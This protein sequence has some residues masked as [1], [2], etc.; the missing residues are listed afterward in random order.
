MTIPFT[1]HTTLT[2]TNVSDLDIT[3]TFTTQTK[4]EQIIKLKN[5]DSNVALSFTG[6]VNP[7]CIIFNSTSSFDI[8]LTKGAG[9]IDL[10]IKNGIPFI[11]PIDATTLA[12]FSA[13]TV[14]TTATTDILVYIQA[15]GVAP[16]A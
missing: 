3:N 7:L 10:A 2:G 11:L 5:T 8:H 6:I 15:Y 4:S 16:T 12:Q 13:I 1:L 14:S 9:T